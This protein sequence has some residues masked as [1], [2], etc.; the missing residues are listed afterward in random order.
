MVLIESCC[1]AE[2]VVIDCFPGYVRLYL[3]SNDDEDDLSFLLLAS[4]SSPVG[5]RRWGCTDERL[6]LLPVF[7]TFH[8]LANITSSFLYVV[9]NIFCPSLLRS[10]SSPCSSCRGFQHFCW[11]LHCALASCGEVYCN[12]SCLWVC[13]FAT[14]GWAGEMTW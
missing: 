9:F 3:S 6:P 1:P 4:P 13:V 8:C 10:A 2:V 12:R 14:S 5:C 7:N 11:Q